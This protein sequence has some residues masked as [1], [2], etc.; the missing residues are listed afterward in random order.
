MSAITPASA[1]DL[2]VLEEQLGRV[3]RGVVGI[4][5]RCVCG[6]PTVVATAPRLE[7]GTPFPTTFYLTSPGAVRACSTL[8]ATKVMEDFN[9][10]LAD[11]EDLRIAYQRAHEA[12]IAAREELGRELQLDVP[13]I[14]GVSAGGMPTRVKCLHAV[15][16]HALAAG[17]GVNPIGDRALQ[18]MQER[19]LWDSQLC[20][21]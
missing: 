18:M 3:P 11:D 10:D 20:T 7:D 6:K 1:E 2:Q 5:A 4:A 19:G 15:V 12:Y 14:H 21:C 13:E 17:Q 9:Q 16:G 8:E